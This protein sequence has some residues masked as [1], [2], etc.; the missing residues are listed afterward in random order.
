MLTDNISKNKIE[1]FNEI[2]ETLNNNPNK[3]TLAKRYN[4]DINFLISIMNELSYKIEALNRNITNL[5]GLDTSKLIS[6]K[7]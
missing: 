2:I 3:V 4:D 1:K 5:S 6:L 7:G